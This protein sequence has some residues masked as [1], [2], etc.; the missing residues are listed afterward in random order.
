MLDVPAPALL[1]LTGNVPFCDSYYLDFNES[2]DALTVGQQALA[3]GQTLY[4]LDGWTRPSVGRVEIWVGGVKRRN[5]PLPDGKSAV[6]SVEK[7]MYRSL[8]ANLK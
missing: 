3:I 1:C 2:F 4:T 8:L 7:T 6:G 5:V